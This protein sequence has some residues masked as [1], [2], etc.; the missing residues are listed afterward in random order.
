VASRL[1]SL[2]RKVGLREEVAVTGGCAK[3]RGLTL[4]LEKKLKLKVR[5]PEVD[6]QVIGALGAALI[7]EERLV[8]REGTG[9]GHG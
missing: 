7:A 5:A 2:A 6:P 4:A 9:Q 1:S 8:R 3:N